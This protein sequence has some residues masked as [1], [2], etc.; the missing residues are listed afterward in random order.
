MAESRALWFDGPQHASILSQPLPE[1]K[2]GW[3]EIET[4]Y[5]AVSPGTER[6]VFQGRVPPEVYGEMRCPYMGGEFPFPVKY[7]YSLVGR[8]VQGEA[9]LVDRLVYVMH[10]HQHRCMVRCEDTAPIPES[11][12]PH[13]AILAAGLETA[14]NGVWDS[15]VTVGERALVAGFGLIG[16]LTARLLSMIPG[17]KVT[18]TDFDP[19]KISLAQ[20]MWF[21]ACRP[22]DVDDFDLAF[23]AS[24]SGEGLQTAIDHVGYQGRVIELS[25]Y[26]ALE[27]KLQLGGSFHSGRKSILSS[28]VSHIPDRLHS[29]WDRRRRLDLVFSLLAK[30]EFDNHITHEIRFDDLPEWFNRIGAEPLPGLAYLVNYRTP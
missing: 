15:G 23:N 25:W 14:L 24:A 6:L 20:R 7:G 2:P 30:P 1:I 16:S 29:R 5:S 17:V 12:P 22:C 11:L 9:D 26:G 21:D 27:V 10:P 13:R 19:E 8:V 28:Q 18:V 4:L 3:C